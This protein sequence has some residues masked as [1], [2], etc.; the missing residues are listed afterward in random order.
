MVSLREACYPKISSDFGV[1]RADFY[2]AIRI[3]AGECIVTT[4][5]QVIVQVTEI[6]GNVVISVFWIFHIHSQRKFAVGIQQAC[7]LDGCIHTEERSEERRVGKECV[8]T[9]RSRGSPSH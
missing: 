7:H 9:C 8:S 4:A 6:L 1:G 2:T 5:D 3:Q